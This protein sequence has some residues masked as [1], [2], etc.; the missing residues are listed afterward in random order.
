[1]HTRDPHFITTP[2]GITLLEQRIRVL[3]SHGK[4]QDGE[5]GEGE[6]GKIEHLKGGCIIYPETL[7]QRLLV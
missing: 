6:H 4:C 1:M 2:A 3:S 7:A 5:D